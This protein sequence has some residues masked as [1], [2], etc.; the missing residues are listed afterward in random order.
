MTDKQLT[1]QEI[2][3]I[4][5]SCKKNGVLELKF[6]DLALNFVQNNEPPASTTG[7]SLKAGQSP[8]D[9]EVLD[10]LMLSNPVAYED[11][12]NAESADG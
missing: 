2:C 8:T 5:D 10:E 3:K 7:F 4:I 6:K 1:A 9:A 11:A 12:L